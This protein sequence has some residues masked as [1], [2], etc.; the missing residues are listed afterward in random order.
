MLTWF[1]RAFLCELGDRT[2]LITCILSAWC[3]WEGPRDRPGLSYEMVIER[4]LVW[5]GAVTGLSL[6]IYFGSLIKSQQ[7]QIDGFCDCILAACMVIMMSKALRDLWRAEEEERK[8]KE[9]LQAVREKTPWTFGGQFLGTGS[10]NQAADPQANSYGSVPGAA[11]AG[12]SKTDSW[13][14]TSVV[15]AFP[16]AFGLVFCSESGRESWTAT[17]RPADF[18]DAIGALLG[19]GTAMLVAMLIGFILSKL[20]DTR[21][22][23]LVTIVLGIVALGSTSEAMLHLGGLEAIVAGKSVTQLLQIML[24]KT[25]SSFLHSH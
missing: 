16:L 6:W 14:V 18:E 23:F 13:G 19:V 22:L 12:D 21:L 2:F 10:A 11:S 8:E 3:P 20:M 17:D 1:L 9:K 24:N 4:L 7:G 15:L 25:G 5:G